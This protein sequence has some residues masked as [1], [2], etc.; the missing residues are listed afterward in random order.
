MISFYAGGPL[1]F[2]FSEVFSNLLAHICLSGNDFIL[3]E[4]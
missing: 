3:Q 4:N 2:D 1:Q